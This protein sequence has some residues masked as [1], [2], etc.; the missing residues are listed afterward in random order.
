M[1]NSGGL[2]GP[3]GT[4]VVNL[5]RQAVGCDTTWTPVAPGPLSGGTPN[6]KLLWHVWDYGYARLSNDASAIATA[7]TN[8]VGFFQGQETYG[9]YA[10]SANANEVLT[11]S[12]Y[13]IWSNGTTCARLLAVVYEDADVL[14]AT[15]AWWHGERALYDLLQ[16]GGSID[17]PG[18]RIDHGGP[19]Q[20]RDVIYAMLRGA[21][22]TGNPSSPTSAWWSDYYNVGAWQ[23][24]EILRLGDDLGGATSPVDK[25]QVPKLRD[26]LYVRTKGDD[27]VFEFTQMRGALDP[28][29]WVAHIG[30]TTTYGMPQ[31]GTPVTSPMAA[32][33]LV[34]ADEFVVPGTP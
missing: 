30:G 25:S 20:L 9:Q 28:L 5:C 23:L 31:N 32:P 26:P 27:W 29:F 2:E 21:A 3:L 15:G 17:A 13:E 4:A 22:L 7:R 6:Q 8:L 33:A 1:S 18:A 34:G 16:R 10:P 24:R 19:S 12:H 11:T 14:S